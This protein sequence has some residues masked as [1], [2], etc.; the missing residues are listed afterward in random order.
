[1]KMPLKWAQ[2]YAPFTASVQDFSDKMTMSGSKVETYFCEADSMSRV[3]VGRVDKL[4]RHENSDHLWVCAINTGSETVQIVTGAQNLKEGDLCPVALH[5]AKL[6][7]G[8]EIRRGKLRGV[9]SHG[10]LCSLGELGLD[11]R[12]FPNAVE[13][14]ILVLEEEAPLGQEAAIA[15][16]MDDVCFE[17]EITPNRPDCLS[18]LGLSR[19]AAATFNVPF[20]APSPTVIQG[21][22]NIADSLKVDIADS[23]LC[24]RYCAAMVDN[25]RVKPSPRWMRERL[26]LCG[27]RPINNIVDITNY[28]ML[29]YGQP[30]HAFDHAYVNGE[31]IT[32]RR[33]KQNEH[34][35]TLDGVERALEPDMLV[36]ADEKSPI[37]LAGVMGGEFSG[38]YDNTKRVVFEAASFDGPAV[39]SAAKRV[40]LRTESS[41][42][43]E[44]GLDPEL[45]MPALARAMELIVELDAGD[46]VGGVLDVYPAPRTA[47]TL[48]FDPQSVNRLLGIEVSREKM[49][50]ILTP[51][52]F[53]VQGNDITVPSFR[54][55]VAKTCDI[56]EEIAR[57]IG[58]NNIPMTILTGAAKAIPTERQHFERR[59]RSLLCGFGLWE[60]ETFSFYGAK[61]FDR[62]HLS[63]NSPLRHAVK[64]MNPLGE[65]TSLMRTTALPSVMD[66]IS[67]NW[68]SRN[69]S[70]AL[71]EV[72]TE[73]LP[74]DNDDE[75]PKEHQKLVLA[76]YGTH[77]D[78]QAIKGVA[79]E[80]FSA[81]GISIPSLLVR[82][83]AEGESYHPGRC[84]DIFI[85]PPTQN[86][87]TEEVLLARLGELHPA[88]CEAYDVPVRVMAAEIYLTPL[89]V[90]QGGVPQYH[91]L[92]RFPAA[93]R[94]LALVCEETLPAGD[95]D[96]VIRKA[97]GKRL[98]SLS[99]FDIYRGEKLGENKKSLAYN[100]VLRSGEGTLTD[101]EADGIIGKILKNLEEIGAV[102]RS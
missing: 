52:G 24:F 26:R 84:A 20:S 12:D 48:A 11:L 7:N 46:L 74:S 42:R 69:E 77:W 101:E 6:P 43:F 1:M 82:R 67:R 60:C 100:L 65:D 21:Q 25:V 86:G 98:E 93:T 47:R 38:I 53:T 16:G 95:V 2:S 71:Y 49:V 66:V 3:V 59:L 27:V 39:R 75:L 87:A 41:G 85:V 17:F 80:L 22:G 51:L 56:A 9:E 29:E 94:D 54:T 63:Q 58:Y 31:H 61:N 88:V 13:D 102:L 19:E 91:P 55:D 81:F 70:A 36:I 90:G 10:M 57:F 68:A 89:Y 37:A 28:V 76:T 5:G 23:D 8:T 44:K 4:E 79:E 32:V 40:G 15:L 78:Y 99:L 14:G 30:M 64:I 97:G 73:Y 72:A 35:V 50:E 62:I 45:V 33:A 34:I 92:P 96:A 83:N 18:V